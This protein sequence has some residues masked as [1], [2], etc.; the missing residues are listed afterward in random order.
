MF[1]AKPSQREYFRLLFSKIPSTIITWFTHE[2][3]VRGRA[4]AI[5][6]GPRENRCSGVLMFSSKNGARGEK[7]GSGNRPRFIRGYQQAIS[8][9]AEWFVKAIYKLVC[10][11]AAV[12][13]CSRLRVCPSIDARSLYRRE[14]MSNSPPPPFLLLEKEEGSPCCRG[15]SCTCRDTWITGGSNLSKA[16]LVK[17]SKL[18][19]VV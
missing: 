14:L 12:P 19:N 3:I 13:V 17:S 7:R 1:R 11:Q 6:I 8:R 18:V 5:N 4:K 15:V 2:N 10:K 9:L 16:S